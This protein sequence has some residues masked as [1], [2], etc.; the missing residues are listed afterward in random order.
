MKGTS[1]LLLTWPA[2]NMGFICFSAGFT[3]VPY[4]IMI[5]VSSFRSESYYILYISKQ[6][7][8]VPMA[9]RGKESIAKFINRRTLILL[10]PTEAWWEDWRSP[11][12]L[13][14]I[15]SWVDGVD[16]VMWSIGSSECSRWAEVWQDRSIQRQ[17]L[18][19][20]LIASHSSNSVSM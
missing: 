20:K 17:D 1:P 14:V 16:P 13:L 6:D 15:Q 9:L 4:E 19:V 3:D 8:S 2:N 11:G 7:I 10:T 12:S 5:S 18:T